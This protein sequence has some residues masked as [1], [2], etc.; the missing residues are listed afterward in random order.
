MRVSIFTEMP[1]WCYNSVQIKGNPE[2]IKKFVEEVHGYRRA[3]SFSKVI[4]EPDGIYERENEDGGVEGGLKLPGWYEWCCENW[5]TKWDVESSYNEVDLHIRPEGI[6]YTF[7]TAWAPSVPVFQSL[8]ERYPNLEIDYIYCDESMDFGGRI[9]WKNG[10]P[11]TQKNLTSSDKEYGLV[12]RG[13]RLEEAGTAEAGWISDIPVAIARKKA[14]G[15]DT[16]KVDVPVTDENLPEGNEEKEQLRSDK[17]QKLHTKLD[18]RTKLREFL[19]KELLRTGQVIG[20]DVQAWKEAGLMDGEE[21]PWDV[22]K[23]ADMAERGGWSGQNSTL[24]MT[25]FHIKPRRRRGGSKEEDDGELRIVLR[26]TPFERKS[27]GNVRI[28]FGHIRI[29]SYGVELVAPSGWSVTGLIKNGETAFLV[30]RHNGRF[31]N[32][33]GGEPACR[34]WTVSPT[35]GEVYKSGE[36]FCSEGKLWDPESGK[37]A[38]TE[39]YPTGKTKVEARFFNH[40]NFCKN[41]G[42]AV[43]VRNEDGLIIMSR[44]GTLSRGGGESKETQKAIELRIDQV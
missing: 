36:A 38:F 30:T 6:D 35:T 15:E 11:V 4:P 2:I 31:Q 25:R 23:K 41:G 26:E 43:V 28:E 17:I 19:G 22:C 7:H 12:T 16:E 20:F 10:I 9:R 33:I 13:M 8:A 34:E 3:L 44:S 21:G 37:P 42:R 24:T 18:G 40:K 29:F 32:Q 5:G 39:W 27:T 1:N 14:L